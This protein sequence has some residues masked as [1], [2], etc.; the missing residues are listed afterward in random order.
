MKKITKVSLITLLTVLFI[1]VFSVVVFA[2]GAGDPTGIK[3]AT[4]DQITSQIVG[5]PS[6]DEIITQIAKIN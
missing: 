3:S 4:V 1:S 2:Q 5:S 6:Q